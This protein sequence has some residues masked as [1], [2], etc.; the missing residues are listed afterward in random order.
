[1]SPSN[2]NEEN[3]N[4]WSVVVEGTERSDRGATRRS[5][6]ALSNPQMGHEGVRTLYEAFRRGAAI[7]PLGP[8][9]GF[10]A[11][12]TNGFPTPFIYSSYTE[13][14]ARV[15]AFA[16]GLD[17]LNL[18][19]ANDDGMKVL[20][21]YMK[22]CMEWI[23]AEHATYTVGGVVAPLYDTLGPDTVRFI[24]DQTQSKT[25]VCT[26]AELQA[27][28]NAKQSGDCPHFTT[29]IVVDGVVPEAATMAKAAGLQLLSFAHVEA[30]GA[31]RI[32]SP[33]GHQHSPPSYKDVCTFCYTSGTTGNP[34]GA[35]MTHE[36]FVSTIAGMVP[37]FDPQPYERH[38][39]YLPLA[40]IF[41]RVVTSQSLVAGASIAFYRG[42]PIY[43]IEDLQACRPT[44]LPV[45]PRVLNKIY[46]K[47][48]AG[49][50]A[51]GTGVKVQIFH[52]ALA[53]KTRNLARGQL[54]HALYDRLVFNKIKKALGLDCVR[55]MVSGSAP[56]SEPVMIFFRCLLGVP[57]VEGYGQTEGTAAA[58]ISHPDDIATVGHVG[59]PTGA[60]EIC[61][62]DVPEMGYL[63]SDTNHRGQPC[64]GRG[65]IC[66]RGPNVFAGYY[67]EPEKTKETID[68]EGW[69]H[70]GDIGLWRT[71]GQ[72]QIIDRK[73]NIFKL[74][75]GEY[76]A[77]EKIENIL[78]QSLLIG[79]CFV[80]GDSF[81]NCLVAI[82]VPDEEPVRHW[83]STNAPSLSADA[84]FATI[85]ASPDLKV[86]LLKDI[87]SLSR[88]Q[89][90]HGFETV[91]DIYVESE[92]F[93]A[94][95]DLVTP[96]FKLKRNK[97]RDAYQSDIDVMYKDMPA[98]KS[99]L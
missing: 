95:N 50:A 54:T 42:N 32:A 57:I 58:T 84:S 2:E 40:H 30:A 93:T 91:R 65:E 19:Q 6:D 49:I 72:L 98:P 82:V 61:L 18:L 76:V 47:I 11:M 20:C 63:H 21:L 45:A 70:S 27:A 35:L 99:R 26:R 79:Q 28:C 23:L 44:A 10:R 87:T 97:L 48:M 92:L 9:L 77:P 24:L 67:K 64:Q 4:V 39:S 81:Q 14:L 68:E 75:I 43:L 66:V 1:M 69:L 29:V 88:A 96:T 13:C 71:Q 38:L 56:L 85:C 60:T 86:A 51:A 78:G 37:F 33:R 83:A 3:D 41:E 80:Y 16:A 59:G 12:S 52:A 94:E 8:C 73:K 5:F 74:S 31:Q 46:D 55:F 22:N 7:N 36:N 34:K 25:I 62:M 53:A 89:G 17:E 15:N 90:L